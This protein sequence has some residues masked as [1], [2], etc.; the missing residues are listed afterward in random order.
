MIAIARLRLL[1]PNCVR[2]HQRNQHVVRA[3][4][5]PNTT[6][7]RSE[8]RLV[9]RPDQQKTR[10]AGS[11]QREGRGHDPL[12]R[13][14]IGQATDQ[15]ATGDAGPEDQDGSGSPCAVGRRTFFKA[16]VEED[17]HWFGDILDA[18]AMIEQFTSGMDFEMFRAS[19][20]AV[21]PV[22]RK[23]QIICADF[24]LHCSVRTLA[25]ERARCSGMVKYARH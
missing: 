4:A 7:N 15:Q 16:F 6:A 25:F 23:L 14:S 20:M 3:E 1:M 12:F 11:H 19:P 22:E 24:Q 5:E 8:Q 2:S 13:R 21:A 17:E 9:V 18:I 10:N